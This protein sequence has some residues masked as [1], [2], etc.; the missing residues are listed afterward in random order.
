MKFK[1]KVSDGGEPWWEEYDKDI[2][3]CQAGAEGFINYFN[4]TLQTGER[5][6]ILHEV[7]LLDKDS[8]K[9]HKWRKMNL[10][11][12]MRG[13]RMFDI[14]KCSRCGITA[15][16]Y[17]LDRIILDSKYNRAKVYQRCDTSMK[18]LEAVKAT[19]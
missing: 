3:D 18:H 14:L 1:M 19:N 13:N 9:Q 7:V 6:R 16:R 8:I 4:S 2:E 15:K 11:T 5:P 17:G 10:V 12:Q